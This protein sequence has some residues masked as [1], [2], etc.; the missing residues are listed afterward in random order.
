MLRRTKIVA[1]LGPATNTDE[2]IEQ[3]IAAGADVFR[4]N[5]SHGD[6]DDHRDRAAMVRRAAKKLGRHVAI[7]GASHSY[8]MRPSTAMPAT[9]NRSVSTTRH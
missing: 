8:W 6:A 2:K 5:F 9:K 1:T 7:L 3:L 4:L